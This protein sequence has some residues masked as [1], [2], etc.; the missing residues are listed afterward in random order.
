MQHDC[1][2]ND[3]RTGVGCVY[4]VGAG[5]GD[6]ELLTLKGRKLLETANVVVFDRL[7]SPRLLYHVSPEAER[8]YVGKRTGRHTVDQKDINRI[9]VERALAGKSVVRLKGGD[10]FIFGRGGEEAQILVENC[11]P[12]EV[13]PGVTSGVA[14]PAYAGIPLTHR[15]Y[16]ASVA[17][18]TG[19]RRFEVKDVD[20]D[21]EGLAKG[22]GTLVFFM[23]M[24]SLPRI[25]GH[26]IRYGR[27]P[28]TPV[29][30]IQWGTTHRQKTI[31]GNLDN[32]ARKV[33]DAGLAP[34]AM[35]IVG[36]VVKLRKQ[37]KW[38]ENRPL[39]GKRILVTRTRE[40]ASDL[41]RLLEQK[42]AFCI[43]C[44][45]IEICPPEDSSDLDRAIDTISDFS[46]II[47]SSTNAVR[48]FFQHFFSQGRDIRSLG[49][50]NIASVGTATSEA[51]KKFHLKP[52]LMPSEFRA[53][54]LIE[55]F[56]R[57][58]I[59]G[60][61]ILV[62][63]AGKAREILPDKLKEMG[64]DVTIVTAYQTRTPELQEGI[65]DI[66]EEE[67]IDVITFTSS[68]TVRNFFK[69]LPEKIRKHAVRS[70]EIACIGPIT[71]DT[72][73]A[74]DLHVSIQPE[75]STIP[76]LV[77]AIEKHLAS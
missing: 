59:E 23:G 56:S 15:E 67:P 14:V 42:G 41:V 77:S 24:S 69:V 20:V 21:W 53:E 25:T 19:H 8:I 1:G 26:L 76:S 30:V 47:F 36:N 52:D 63:R 54:G 10:P 45:T 61:K 51:L 34:P 71:A 17:L 60:E 4:L 49:R 48:F 5:P 72:A 66:M 50:I 28:D 13:V 35:I 37:I 6:P 7:A 46:W 74:H 57:M 62:P 70:A 38:F 39:W 29:A 12:F 44:P 32:I 27:K 55:E 75:I 2:S 43:E 65:L 58:E 33:R 73:E 18:I 64:A 9:I 3:N 40:Q 68:S 11:I 31:T 16:T 22:V